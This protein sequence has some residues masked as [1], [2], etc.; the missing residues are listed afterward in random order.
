MSIYPPQRKAKLFCFQ[1]LDFIKTPIMSLYNITFSLSLHCCDSTNAVEQFCV[2]P[3]VIHPSERQWQRSVIISSVTFWFIISN[4]LQQTLPEACSCF[5]AQ[6]FQMSVS[7]LIL[8]L[9]C[10]QL[11]ASLRE[12]GQD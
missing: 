2:C 3:Q 8:H 10:M 7:V 11:F 4:G 12:D 9:F 5:V 6:W 1:G